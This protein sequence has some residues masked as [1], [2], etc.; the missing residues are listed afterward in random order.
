MSNL[1]SYIESIFDQHY[2]GVRDTYGVGG[3][4]PIEPDGASRSFC[5]GGVSFQMG[6]Y[7]VRVG[8]NILDLFDLWIDDKL[9][10]E[11]V[12]VASFVPRLT[13]ALEPVSIRIVAN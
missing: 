10:F 1:V 6:G 5:R 9:R 2:R 13:S 12:D 3:F 11:D 4:A 7:E 8:H